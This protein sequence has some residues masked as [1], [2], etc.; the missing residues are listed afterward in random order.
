MIHASQSKSYSLQMG[1]EVTVHFLLTTAQISCL[2]SMCYHWEV[3]EGIPQEL[4]VPLQE[5]GS[6]IGVP[7]L[8]WWWQGKFWSHLIAHH[9]GKFS[10]YFL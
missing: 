10:S 3:E 8:S 6:A 5:R 1:V 4:E 9:R 7:N 2:F